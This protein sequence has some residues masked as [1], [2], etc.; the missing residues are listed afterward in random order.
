VK[1]RVLKNGPAQGRLKTG[2]GKKRE[3]R[4]RKP[5]PGYPR[6][7]FEKSLIGQNVWGPAKLVN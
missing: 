3:S 6:S 7:G 4:D 1:K 5:D 2:D